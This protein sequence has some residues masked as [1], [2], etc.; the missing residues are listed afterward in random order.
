MIDFGSVPIPILALICGLIVFS[1]GT[2][3]ASDVLSR[4]R[5]KRT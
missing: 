4:R 2:V 3:S 1:V 5:P